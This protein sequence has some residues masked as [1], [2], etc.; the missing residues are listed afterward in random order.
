MR[1]GQ[2]RRIVA[3][4]A[5][6]HRQRILCH[7]ARPKSDCLCVKSSPAAAA[8]VPGRCGRSMIDGRS[9]GVRTALFRVNLP[10]S[11]QLW[12]LAERPMHTKE[13]P[14][15]LRHWLLVSRSSPGTDCTILHS[16]LCSELR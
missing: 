4:I 13:I 12:I 2:A 1:A 14:L 6:L 3:Q 16:C 7:A 15:L 8:H 10:C 9:F 11:V 5:L